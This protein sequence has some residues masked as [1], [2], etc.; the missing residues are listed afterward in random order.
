MAE[1]RAGRICL[2][3]ILCS[4]PAINQADCVILLHGLA[5]TS[6]SMSEVADRLSA[7]GYT[8]VNQDY[9][10]RSER[11]ETLAAQ[12][13]DR[14]RTTC[15]PT[16]TIHF[17][18]HSLGGI[19][20]RYYLTMHKLDQLGRVVML[21]PPNQGSEVVDVWRDV[22]GF[23][24]LN[25]PA[26]MQLGTD[27]NSVPLTLGPVDFPLGVIAGTAT[28]NPILSRSLPDPD[29]GKVSVQSTQVEGMQ[30]FIAVPHSHTFIMRSELVQD[31]ILT[32]LKT[33]HFNHN[34]TKAADYNVRKTQ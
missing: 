20:V 24:L 4:V 19:L 10:S 29:D 6:G 18:T 2:A 32:F 34:P 27:S 3:A 21:A 17:V 16:S 11:I 25:G 30:D 5:R 13:I 15:E 22:P 7:E 9:P 23:E 12:T 28:I 1:R 26:G 8:V 33:G 31:Q 14:A